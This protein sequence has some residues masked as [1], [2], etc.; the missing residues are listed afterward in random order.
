M[1]TDLEALLAETRWLKD[2]EQIKELPYLYALGIDTRDFDQV[3][4]VFHPDC[5]V[6]GTLHNA[7]IREYLTLLEPGVRQYPATM[8]F[9]GNQYVRVDG[10]SGHVE[11]YAVAYHMEA[12]GS[13][14]D[15]LVMGVRYQD[16]VVRVPGPGG[17]DRPG[18]EAGQGGDWKILRRNV[19]RQWSRGPLPRPGQSELEEAARSGS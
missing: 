6:Q 18:A 1:P 16:D 17:V 13:E 15:D 2:R 4:S 12:D 5:E 14:L 8:H 10:D 19:V 3:A 7:P 11:T 9:M